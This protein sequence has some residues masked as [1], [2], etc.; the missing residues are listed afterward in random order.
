MIAATW[1]NDGREAAH[2]PADARPARPDSR[3]GRDL[4]GH[5]A[6]LGYG[7]GPTTW[8]CRFREMPYSHR[9]CEPP[10]RSN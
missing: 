8:M 10:H 6:C 5:Q 9:R 2:P 3:A 7:V 4:V 1:W